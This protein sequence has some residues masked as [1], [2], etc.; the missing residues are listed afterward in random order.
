MAERRFAALDAARGVA[1][2]VMALYHLAFDLQFFNG[3]ALG[4]ESWQWQLFARVVAASFLFIAGVSL[5]ISDSRL[6]REGRFRHHFARGARI[7]AAGILITI[8]TLALFP[9]FAIWWGVLH[10][11]GFGVAALWIFAR[12]PGA[13]L[14]AAMVVLAVSALPVSFEGMG[15]WMLW[16]G[17]PPAGFQSFDY[18]PVIPWAAPFLLGIWAGRHAM[19]YMNKHA[20]VLPLPGV[21]FIAW[22]GRNSLAVYLAHQPVLVA[23]VL[24]F[25]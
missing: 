24:A 21:A 4:V 5:Y 16:A 12:R 18:V 15:G 13:A 14:V 20:V 22:L 6:S 9:K 10:C 1:L 8:V 17:F 19:R 2:L 11:I 23:L 3:Y 25:G 7:F